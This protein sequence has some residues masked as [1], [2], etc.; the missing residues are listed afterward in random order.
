MATAATATA[1]PVKAKGSGS[2][3]GPG[4]GPYGA[5][6]VLAK[7]TP[8]AA[9]V[10]SVAPPSS[11][12]SVAAA[13]SVPV[14]PGIIA[15]VSAVPMMSKREIEQEIARLR[16]QEEKIDCQLREFFTSLTGGIGSRDVD[17]DVPGGKGSNTKSRIKM[18]TSFEGSSDRDR[19]LRS[20]VAKIEKFSPCF[21]AMVQDARKLG[22]QVE[23]CRLLSDRISLIV[24]RLDSIQMRAQ[25]CL[26]CTEDIINLKD[27]KVKIVAAMEEG[28]LPLAVSFV[29]QV[30]EV[31]LQA[32]R[33][34]DDFTAIQRAE[35]Q[36]RELVKAEFDKA[37][38]ENDITRVMSL[39]PLFQTLG[40]ETVARDSFLEF[41]EKSVFTA[42]SA[43]ATVESSDP[44]TAYAQALSNIFN[45]TYS[46]FQQ[47]LPM[48]IQGMENS[49][50]D[51]HFIRRMH[52]KC[53]HEAAIV[54]KR[55]IK[56]R[57]LKEIIASLKTPKHPSVAD[58]H[59]LLD[60]VALLL[61]Y[62]CLYSKYLSQLC[63][64]AEARVRNGQGSTGN[65]SPRGAHT[66]GH[67]ASGGQ[68]FT[69]GHTPGHTPL[70][71]LPTSGSQFHRMVEEIVNHMYMIGEQWLIEQGVKA[72][73][74]NSL[75]EAVD[76]NN[77]LDECFFVL[78]RC[79]QR[80]IATNNIQVACA[81]LQS[82]SN[83]LSSN[84][85]SQVAEL[86]NATIEKLVAVAHEQCAKY[87]KTG[88]GQLSTSSSTIGGEAFSLGIKNA[89]N[90]ATQLTATVGASAATMGAKTGA[91]NNLAV[92]DDTTKAQDSF[93]E[94]D[95]F[96]LANALQSFNI[97]EICVRYT[98]RLTKEIHRTGSTVF[99]H[100]GGHGSHKI[101]TSDA[102][103][104][105]IACESL[106]GSKLTFQQV[107]R[108]HF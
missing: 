95:P 19:D 11:S 15:P 43:D 37:I 34:S 56:F 35:V 20:N 18:R 61:Q 105:Q 59:G 6:P 7:A 75:D 48:V 13:G 73:L 24:R 103:R 65:A 25:Q 79:G 88:T 28:N 69:P 81:I 91:I 58:M 17:K 108:L 71:D 76:E 45:T 9:P 30:H 99:A 67:A 52:A 26:A 90:I 12:K 74:P 5:T 55:Y 102:D 21:E 94:E 80:A 22:S 4:H 101:G 63:L 10:T 51:V 8:S 46:I 2:G 53:E 96:G 107:D 98:E 66:P 86:I 87:C 68:S 104:L 16:D 92:K 41:V 78:R 64:G 29:K 36:L 70:S 14:V 27:C 93:S 44:A 54:L 50:G 1:T 83:L 82:I 106:E 49:H 77:G 39:C 40:L 97:V 32:A 100:A 33:T 47:Y 31:D 3:L 89:M 72:T 23:D 38:A 60:E 57:N 84:L 42:V 62:C 85:H